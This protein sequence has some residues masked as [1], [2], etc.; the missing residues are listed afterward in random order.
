M[1]FEYSYFTSN[2]S[3]ISQAIIWWCCLIHSAVT[4][5]VLKHSWRF[6]LL[7]VHRVVKILVR[8]DLWRSSG[9][10]SFASWDPWNTRSGQSWLYPCESWKVPRMQIS[11]FPWGNNSMNLLQCCAVLVASPNL[12][13]W[14]WCPLPLI[15]LSVTTEKSFSPSPSWL[16]FKQ[17]RLLIVCCLAVLCWTEEA[18]LPHCSLMANDKPLLPTVLVAPRWTLFSFPTS[19]SKLDTDSRY[20]LASAL[21]PKCLNESPSLLTSEN[22]YYFILL[23]TEFL[24]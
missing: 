16:L 13:N 24:H 10:T 9:L 18:Q 23:A 12:P 1:Q 5:Q 3:D 4:E 21:H 11:L 17:C 6:V 22:R 2:V 14:N 20:A 8:R 19:P 15:T 7:S